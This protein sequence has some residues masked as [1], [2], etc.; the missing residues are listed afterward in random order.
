VV[1]VDPV[2]GDDESVETPVTSEISVEHR[3]VESALA[4]AAAAVGGTPRVGQ[5]LMAQAVLNALTQGTHLL[6]QAGTGTGKSLAYLVPSMLRATTSGVGPVVIATATLALQRQLVEHDAPAIGPA[7]ADLM[8]RPAIV[9]VLKGR[10]NY[11][12]RLRLSERDQKSVS[13]S[14]GTGSPD[15]VPLF[16][17]DTV[18]SGGRL[19]AQAQIVSRWANETESGDRDD[20]PEPIDARVWRAFSVSSAE[21]VGR[22]RC[23]VGEECFAEQARD[24]AREADVIVTNHAMLALDWIEGVPVLPE[25][26]GV[27]IDEAHEWI[28]R[29]T[30]AATMELSPAGITALGAAAGRLG[31]DGDSVRLVQEAQDLAAAILVHVGQSDH[32]R[33]KQLP[34]EIRDCAVIIREAARATL[35]GLS[36]SGETRATDGI[37]AQT[38]ARQRLRAG[39]DAVIHAIDRLL[40]ADSDTVVWAQR[41]P[42][43]ILIAPLSIGDV[44]KA[45]HDQPPVI[46]TSATLTS[47]APVNRESSPS[48]EPAD[49]Q[50]MEVARECGLSDQPWVGLDVGSPFD[51]ARQGI[52]YVA[53]HLPEPGRDGIAEEALDE[54]AE[55]VEAAG[56]R[57][58]VL[59]SS[60]RAVERAGEYL[61]V[62]LSNDMRVL[63][64]QRGEAAGPLI[65]RFR[66][67]IES[68]LLGTIGLWQGV[69]VP[70]NTCRL[71]IIDRIP[72]GRPDD[73]I[74]AARQER[75]EKSG[76]DGFSE[77]ALPRAATMLAQGV[78]RLIRSDEDRGVVAI[79]DPRLATRGYGRRIRRALPPLWDTT[80]PAVV[81]AAL[82]R[83]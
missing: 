55:L 39:L 65:E 13:D 27:V 14:S 62:R 56:G 75:V 38:T 9:S 29:A 47:S 16:D 66:D 63:I 52:L 73:P 6:V 41:A 42:E 7:I 67:D 22:T 59:F 18:M 53:R 80:D 25:Y 3:D 50:F 10:Q 21:C 72:F 48:A 81:R 79:L 4:A 49:P 20:L 77:I 44:L 31:V 74:L 82:M 69:D 58:L 37:D 28:D 40:T 57:S 33:W 30:K 83:L 54:I 46:L 51:Y 43:R 23:P 12:C 34:E 76:G 78:G 32:V 61:R 26:S 5:V 11:L 15:V 70:G 71:V 19:S 64:Q 17:D 1:V 24:A 68:V 60:W 45:R 35:S 36:H 2:S 8:P